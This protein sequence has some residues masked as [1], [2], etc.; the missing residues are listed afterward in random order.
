MSRSYIYTS[1]SNS[2]TVAAN[3]VVLPGSIIHRFGCN[4][5]LNG[6]AV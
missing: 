4:L 1:N 6:D 3:G 2:Q 5:N